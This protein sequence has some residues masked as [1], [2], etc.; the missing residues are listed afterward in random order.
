MT[1]RKHEPVFL[2]RQ[3]MHYLMS[4]SHQSITETIKF[5]HWLLGIHPEEIIR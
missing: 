4:L 1:N 5:G 3:I 2:P